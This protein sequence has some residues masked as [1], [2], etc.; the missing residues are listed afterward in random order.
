MPTLVEA[1]DTFPCF[2]GTCGA[3][4]IGDGRLGSPE[5]AVAHVRRRLEEWHSR[6]TRFEPDSEL[7]ALNADPR[8][9]VPV[10]ATM[11][12][13]AAAVVQAASETGGLVDATLLEPLEDAGYRTDLGAPVPLELALRLV[14]TR[15]PAGP[16]AD[17]SWQTISV[18]RAAGT[19][20]RPVGVRL[21]SG[22]LAKG[23]FA[24]M[25]AGELRRHAS[26][27]IDCAGDLRIGGAKA[28]PR[29]VRVASPFGGR[30]LHEF[31]LSSAGFAT[32]GIGR[33]S[34]LD[35]RGVPAHHL[36]DP[37]TGR[38][39]FTGVV[40]ATA[41]APTALGAEILAKAAV[42]SGPESARGWLPHGG[43]LVYD[44]GEF[45]VVDSTLAA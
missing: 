11:L 38:P 33:R 15:R 28:I 2:G 9:T 8:T 10:S 17:S 14:R 36:L 45:E 41:L 39:A 26:F 12:R 44:D 40:Q 23:L 32:S 4:V 43:V 16:R 30:V 35:A 1:T 25:L 29:P 22:G 13:F 6:F 24:D 37:A 21:D 18:D 19:V 31:E 5:D 27:A 3:F 42:L 7:C 34:W 20:T